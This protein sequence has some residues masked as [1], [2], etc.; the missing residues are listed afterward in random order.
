[1]KNFFTILNLIFFV[2]I[3]NVEAGKPKRTNFVTGN[4]YEGTVVLW[5]GVQ[6]ELPK[7][8][9]EVVAKYSWD[10][11]GIRYYGSTLALLEK[12]T[13]KALTEFNHVDTAGKRT[14]DIDNWIQKVVMINKTDGCYLR[15]EYY[16]V[17]KFQKGSAF[18]CL[19]VRH[20]D[21]MKEM[22]NPD[23]DEYKYSNFAERVFKKWFKK[24][25]IQ[26]PSIMIESQHWFYAK[27]VKNQIVSVGYKINPEMYGADKIIFDSEETSEYHRSN[28]NKHPSAKKFIENFVKLAVKRHKKF[29]TD[30]K[31]KNIHKL[32]LSKYK[33]EEIEK[34][35]TNTNLLED[36]KELKKLYE[37]GAL[38]KEEFEKAKKKILN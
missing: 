36:L 11:L 8:K 34:D 7:G 2:L 14:A 25:N 3:T 38:T 4:I 6:I 33:I 5:G 30:V 10:V 18:N 24:N 20:I 19:V 28:I 21:V 26:A 22:Y 9:W 37:E 35:K 1:M 27:S 23:F 31:A 32:D 29:E 12:N 15:R 16:L 17:E 13:I